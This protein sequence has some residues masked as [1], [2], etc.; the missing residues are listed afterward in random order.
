MRFYPIV[1]IYIIAPLA[2]IAIALLVI[3]L[4]KKKQRNKKNIRRIAMLLL[5]TIILTRPVF[6]GA[7]AQ[8]EYNNL[9]FFFVVDA[10]TSMSA[11]D[12]NGGNRYT[13]VAKDIY[14]IV[15]EF[16]G[17]RY[18]VTVEDSLI[19]TAVPMTTSM[20]FISSIWNEKSA[21]D[22]S[23][24]LVSPKLMSRSNGT[25]L[26][27]L[28]DY[29]EK[30]VVD[31]A[32]KYPN[33]KNIYF[34]MSDGENSL[35]N[36][37]TGYS[38]LRLVIDGGAVLGYG[39][40]DGSPMY[41]VGN[42]YRSVD[43]CISPIISRSTFELDEN[44]CIVSRLNEKILNNIADILSIDY[45]HRE[46]GGVPSALINKINALMSY[47][48]ADESA[49]SFADTYWLFGM[50]LIALLLWD[51]RDVLDSVMREREYKHA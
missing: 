50:I 37:I 10:T 5:M 43:K 23:F 22:S 30:R 15:K 17:S 48:V 35:G 11:R 16:P 42:A 34:F 29:S 32:K 8:S 49:D 19:Y 1:P 12:V 45:Y 21:S 46:T 18:S 36:T 9:N 3:C 25:N 24:G 40:K 41:D 31:Y 33:R 38:S 20:D 28:L 27:E 14:D 47:S 6:I 7:Q 4:A 13:K 44:G 51:F 2:T 26:N 39:S